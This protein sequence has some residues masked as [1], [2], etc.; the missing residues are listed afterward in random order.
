MRPVERL[1]V[2]LAGRKNDFF[3]SILLKMCLGFTLPH[4]SFIATVQG[5]SLC[6]GSKKSAGDKERKAPE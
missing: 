4:N 1:T 3:V 2:G 5:D 6:S